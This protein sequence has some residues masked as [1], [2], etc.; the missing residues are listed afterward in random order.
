MNELLLNT[1]LGGDMY[2]N[3]AKE[4]REIAAEKIKTENPIDVINSKGIPWSYEIL[5]EE[6]SED[7]GPRSL[8][9]TVAVYLPQIV[10]IGVGSSKLT[11]KEV[12][13]IARKVVIKDAINNAL[14]TLGMEYNEFTFT[15]AHI[16]PVNNA[17]VTH[18][19]EEQRHTTGEK[20][21]F[22]KEQVERVNRLKA[23]LNIKTDE[24]F[25]KYLQRWNANIKTKSQLTPD[26]ID[27]FLD[28][29]Q[30]D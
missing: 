1:Y 12:D 5:K 17:P 6:I 13:L 15:Q 26:N 22:S 25:N 16:S 18:Q 14:S 20:K 23:K 3:Y 10:R 21:K 30:I 27:D 2:K 7:L 11:K 28:F 19:T 29:M 4:L 24:E 8:H 9:I